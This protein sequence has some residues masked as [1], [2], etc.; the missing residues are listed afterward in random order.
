[1][2]WSEIQ[3]WAADHLAC[4]YCNAQPPYW[5]TTRPSNGKRLT[6]SLHAGRTRPVYELWRRGYMEGIEDEKYWAQMRQEREAR[7]AN[8]QA[9]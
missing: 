1:M 9:G 3:Q 7:N 8:R 5:C 6:N 4:P 2:T